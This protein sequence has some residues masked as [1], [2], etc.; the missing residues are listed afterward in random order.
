[1]IHT[2]ET[3]PRSRALQLVTAAHGRPPAEWHYHAWHAQ[4]ARN[5]L[6]WVAVRMAIA[7]ELSGRSF[8]VTPPSFPTRAS[9][10]HVTHAY[11]NW[12][13]WLWDCPVCHAAQVCTPADPRG[14]CVECWNA[15][16]GWWPVV[17]PAEFEQINMLLARR[18]EPRHRN[19]LLGES[20]T[21]LQ[22]ENIALGIDPDLPGLPWPGAE[23]ALALVRRHRELTATE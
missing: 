6:D 2:L 23:R 5:G 16:D 1:M 14:Y 4:A 17:F 18:P 21:Q 8:G 10:E 11:A 19:W 15:G 9:V 13:R 3:D 22:A 12:S 20:V 7:E